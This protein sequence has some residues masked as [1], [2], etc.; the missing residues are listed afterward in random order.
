MLTIDAL[1]NVTTSVFD[2]HGRLT[3]RTLPE[4][5][6]TV[7][8]YDDRHNPVTITRHPKP[9]SSAAPIIEHFTYQADLLYTIS[10]AT[11]WIAEQQGT[12]NELLRDERRRLL[13]EAIASLER[14]LE[15]GPPYG[16]PEDRDMSLEDVE[17]HLV[18]WR[19]ELQEI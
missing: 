4:G 3:K 8:A 12:S 1:D 10:L 11:V 16:H 14:A 19:L 2:G 6:F 7:F 9:E 17:L 15:L 5:Q 18:E 13:A